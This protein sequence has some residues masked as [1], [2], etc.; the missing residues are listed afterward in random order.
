MDKITNKTA[1]VK[2]WRNE[3]TRVFA[4]RLISEADVE[5]VSVDLITDLVKRFF[6]EI[7]EDVMVNPLIFGD[8]A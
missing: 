5:L 6:A 8:Y 1:L 7:A 2:L 4:D 3:C